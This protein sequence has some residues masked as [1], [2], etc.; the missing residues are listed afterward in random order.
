[1]NEKQ[2]KR[3]IEDY[4]NGTIG[5]HEKALLDKV[6]DSYDRPEDITKPLENEDL[7]KGDIFSGIRSVGMETYISKKSPVPSKKRLRF[8]WLSVAAAILILIGMGSLYFL[9]QPVK[10]TPA[11]QPEILSLVTDWGQRNTITLDDGTIVTLNAGSQLHY[12]KSFDGDSIRS[13]RLEGEAFFEV[14]KNPD[15][16]FIIKTG[17][18]TTKVLGTSFNI[19]SYDF[20]D[21]I[22]VTVR[23]GKVQVESKSKDGKTK[24]VQLEP[25]EMAQYSKTAYAL[26]KS[27]VDNENYLDWK[28][29]IIRFSDISFDEA[30]KMLSRWYGVA[31]SFENNSLKNCHITARYEHAK[32]QVVLESIKFATKGMDYEF[33]DQRKILLKGHC[34]N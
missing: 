5:Q 22:S 8:Q 25:N 14:A 27:K 15:K 9:D 6:L 13:V 29:G 16:P 2:L 3:L 31:I 24:T 32:L 11:H 1:M 26:T 19:N 18:I 34:L 12:P 10:Q 33:T 28:N 7:I 23:T 30:S 4:L 20:N 17:E 21:M